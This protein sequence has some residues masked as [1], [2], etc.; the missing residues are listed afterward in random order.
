MSIHRITAM[1]PIT[2]LARAIIFYSEGL[3]LQVT[4][5]NDEWNHAMLEGEHGCQVMIDRSI[6]TESNATTVVYYY[7]SALESVRERLIAVG[8]DPEP[9]GETFYGMTEFRVS[10]PDGN[11]V[12]VGSREAPDA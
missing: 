5:R 8:F 2:D 6:R 4:G 10:D 3:G 12:W 1:V 7:T 9:I 11:R